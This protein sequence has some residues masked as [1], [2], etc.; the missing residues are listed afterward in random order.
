MLH[1]F[2]TKT[3]IPWE[4]LVWSLYDPAKA[5]HAQSK[6]GSFWWK[7]IF[8]LNGIYRSITKWTIG[9]GTSILFSKDFWHFDQLLCEE[10]PILFTFT[11]NE[12][13]TVADLISNNAPEDLFDLPISAQAHAKLFT[14][15]EVIN[16]IQIT[17]DTPYSI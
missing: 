10:F 7:D 9:D 16:N 4:H 14:I 1:K 11:K 13:L 6:R 17:T 3:N 12:D 2:Y 15:T 5:P 8:N